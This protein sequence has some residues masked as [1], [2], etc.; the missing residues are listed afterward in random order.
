M[1][2]WRSIDKGYDELIAKDPGSS[3]S[4]HRFRQMVLSG[5]IPSIKAGVKRLIDISTLDEHLRNPNYIPGPAVI[6]N[7]IRRIDA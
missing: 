4:R 1:A 5:E 6:M 3:L 7:G 2:Q